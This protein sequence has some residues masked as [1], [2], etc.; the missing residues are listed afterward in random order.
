MPQISKEYAKALFALASEENKVEEYA[1]ILRT[2]VTVIEENEGYTEYLD[3][4]AIPLSERLGAI[5]SAFASECPEYILSFIK[6]LCENGHITSVSDSIYEFF[7]LVKQWE[8]RA[9]AKVYSAVELTEE[10]KKALCTK[11]EAKYGKRFDAVYIVDK[12]LIGGIKVELEDKILD[13][14]VSKQLH[15]VKGVING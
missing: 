1:R 13:G 10:Q 5:D 4:P 15:M 3:S 9:S 11:L 8:G 6:L 2:V 12:S 14:S 7:E